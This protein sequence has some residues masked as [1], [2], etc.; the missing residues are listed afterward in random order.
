VKEQEYSIRVAKSLRP[1]AKNSNTENDILLLMAQDIANT[2]K[3]SLSKNL[4][5][6]TNK[7]ELISSNTSGVKRK[8]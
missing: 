8:I 2:V 5:K 7:P 4:V 3:I 6:V 1:I